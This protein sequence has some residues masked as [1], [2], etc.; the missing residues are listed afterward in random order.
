[1]G[2]CKRGSVPVRAIA[3]LVLSGLIAPAPAP[4]SD[5]VPAHGIA[6]HGDLAYPADFTHFKYANPDAPKG[7]VLPASRDRDLRQLQSVHR[8]GKCRGGLFLSRSESDLRQID[9]CFKAMSHSASTVCWRRRLKRRRIAPGSPLHCEKRRAGTTVDRSAS[10]TCIWTFNALVEKGSP[11]YGL[12]Y[13][14]VE[15]V[16]KAG[17]RRVKF[18]FKPGR[19]SRIAVDPRP[20]AGVAQA[21]LGESGLRRDDARSTTGSGAYEIESF[22]AGRFV[23]YKRRADYWAANLPVNRGTEQ[24]RFDPL[25]LLSGHGCRRRGPQGGRLRHPRR[26]QPRRSGPP[27]TTS[28]MFAKVDSARNSSPTSETKAHQGFAFNLR[29]PKSF[30]ID[31]CERRFPTRSTSSG[32]IGRSSTTNTS[33][34][35]ATSKTR[36]SPR[37]ACRVRRNSQILEPL[38]GRIPDEVFTQ[39]YQPPKTD[40]SGNI[41]SNLRI[42]TKLLAEAGWK[43]NDGK[44][45][46]CRDGHADGIRDSVAC[47]RVSSGLRF[48]SRRIWSASVSTL[49]VRTVDTSQYRRR[50]DTF[51]FDMTVTTAIGQS[52]SPGNEQRDF[53]LSETANR[54][55][56]RNLMGIQNS[57]IDELIELVI[58]APNREDLVT[59]VHAL[60]RVLQWGFYLIPHW[61]IAA[62]RLIY[63][64]RFG[65]SEISPSR[66]VAID[67]WWYDVEKASRLEKARGDDSR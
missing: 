22:E 60:D 45:I 14:G 52:D 34:P 20:A 44:L 58:A 26:E 19:Q 39:E 13:G 56:G 4:G 54:E 11:L 65:K 31:G 53:W 28:Q 55:G 10:T 64:D 59:R 49:T 51:D 30:E 61:Y 57:A 3:L 15:K 37:E 67:T 41:R 18:T 12:Y 2:A 7:G 29:R 5:A 33:G 35:A 8:E 36:N 47:L 24:L 9:G 42:A 27:P 62:D 48:R 40:G 25:R 46:E 21:L 32:R 1:M 43:I 17:E 66:G 23:H 63:W 6:M 50:M 38:K 16:E